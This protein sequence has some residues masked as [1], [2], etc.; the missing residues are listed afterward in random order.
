MA[1][2]TSKLVPGDVLLYYTNSVFGILI[3]IKTWHPVSHV[4]VFIGNGLSVA[5]RDGKG[6]NFYPLRTDIKYVLRPIKQIDL[7]TGMNWFDRVKGQKYDW[8][9]LLRFSWR[10]RYIPVD[11]DNRQF[12]SEFATRFLRKS[13][14]P[15]FKNED[16]DAIAPCQFLT[17]Y[18]LDDVTP[19]CE[20]KL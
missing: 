10:S 6:V 19:L 15:V 2:D 4:E 13:N 9:G 14:L 3:S 18:Y 17:E 1:I 8:L 11:P 5:S 16:A 7:A 20:Q 12:C